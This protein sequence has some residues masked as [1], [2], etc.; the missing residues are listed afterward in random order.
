MLKRGSGV[1][2]NLKNMLTH[3]LVSFA[4][5]EIKGKMIHMHACTHSFTRTHYTHRDTLFI[6]PTFMSRGTVFVFPY[7]CL[8]VRSFVH[9]SVRVSVPVVELLQSFTVKFLNWG[10]THQ[11]IIRKHSYLDHR[12]PGGLAFIPWLL[13][14]GSMPGDGARGKKLGPL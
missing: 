1:F 5:F 3:L 8:Y 6:H 10:I 2:L 14:P 9:S 12:Y 11:P 13:T 4:S 7:V